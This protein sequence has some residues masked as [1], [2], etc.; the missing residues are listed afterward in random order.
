MALRSN[1]NKP[2]SNIQLYP[3]QHIERPNYRYLVEQKN[4]YYISEQ[5]SA[6]FSHINSDIKFHLDNGPLNLFKKDKYFWSYYSPQKGKFINI[7]F[8][9][10]LRGLKNAA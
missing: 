1:L 2:K 8:W 7:F 4:N 6:V 9:I 10:V 3:P 5:E